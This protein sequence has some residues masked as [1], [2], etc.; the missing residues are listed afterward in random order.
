MLLGPQDL[1]QGV[2]LAFNPNY[3]VYYDDGERLADKNQNGKS[4]K[5]GWERANKD[6]RCENKNPPNIG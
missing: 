5:F 4:Y 6:F 1:S 3:S 2:F